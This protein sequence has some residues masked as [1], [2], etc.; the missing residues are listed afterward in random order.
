M[1]LDLHRRRELR[2]VPCVFVLLTFIGCGGGGGGGGNGG[3]S[4][5][6]P[7]PVATS[8]PRPQKTVV[9]PAG[10]NINDAI[11]VHPSGATI[12]VEGGVYDPIVMTPGTVFGPIFIEAG[13]EDLG[14]ATI[15]GEGE[16][17]AIVLDGQTNV[18]IDGLQIIGGEVAGIY[19]VDSDA[20]E[21]RNC[22]VRR[23]RD[24]VVFER[25]ANGLIFD[26]LFYENEVNNIAGL[27]TSMFRIVN[28]TIFGGD[29]GIFIGSS[30]GDAV[31][32]LA[33]DTFVSNNSIDGQASIG[34][35]VESGSEGD[36]FAG[37]NINRTGYQG[38][39][40]GFLDLASN[41]LFIFPPPVGSEKG[42]LTSECDFH[43]QVASGGRSSPAIDRGDPD[44]DPALVRVLR[45]R[46]IRVD[47]F[48]DGEIIDIGYHYSGGM[49]TPTPFPTT[50]TPGAGG[51]T[52]TPT[53][54]PTN[55][56]N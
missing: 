18:V 16:D 2:A 9:V 8:I 22:V 14:A 50:P 27:G 55:T 48:S 6:P 17:A 28:N 43:V 7:T 23:A 54:T 21:I 24:G 5:P 38:V 37:Y 36:Y 45:D 40:K 25:V 26:T 3:T 52:R 51:P 1:R 10:G 30:P 56:P 41:P 33:G 13:D 44:T 53:A 42:C 20:V 49:V 12:I 15:L 47:N 11:A 29:V 34:I 46:T 4:N 39:P 35:K 19:A 31:A 32:V